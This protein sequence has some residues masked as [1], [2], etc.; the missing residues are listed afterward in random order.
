MPFIAKP[1]VCLCAVAQGWS[2]EFTNI[3][4][5]ISSFLF[6]VQFIF[7]GLTFGI[8]NPSA[9]SV[10][11][12]GITIGA[13]MF[14]GLIQDTIGWE[15]PG[16]LP[17]F[18]ATTICYDS[19]WFDQFNRN[20]FPEPLFVT[21]L[22]VSIV[23]IYVMVVMYKCP[24]PITISALLALFYTAGGITEVLLGRL[25]GGQMLANVALA[26]A[27]SAMGILL[28]Y[29]WI[30]ARPALKYETEATLRFNADLETGNTLHGKLAT[31]AVTLDDAIKKHMEGEKRARRNK[32]KRSMEMRGDSDIV[33]SA[34]SYSN[35]RNYDL[36]I[37]DA[38]IG[39][40]ERKYSSTVGM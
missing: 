30:A 3:F 17:E 5:N 13:Y 36:D 37:S 4:I 27:S 28:A 15:R 24:W 9:L 10:I 34:L 2:D 12:I 32:K 40:F 31:P 19:W 26:F 39:T 33:Y 11:S 7:T 29:A 35:T 25:S 16:G 22:S 1:I 8:L 14:F 23:F 6:I 38:P 20:G 18:C 21:G